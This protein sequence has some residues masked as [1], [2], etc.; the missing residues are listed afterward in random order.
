MSVGF[1]SH[2][3]IA[4]KKSKKLFHYACDEKFYCYADLI[5]GTVNNN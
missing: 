2:A 4:D 3:S 5:W 1:F